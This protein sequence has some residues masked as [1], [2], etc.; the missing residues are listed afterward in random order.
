MCDH[1]PSRQFEVAGCSARIHPRRSAEAQL[2]C[3]AQYPVTGQP[4]KHEACQRL[5]AER[6]CP[7]ILINAGQNDQLTDITQEGRLTHLG[8]RRTRKL[9][10][11]G[12]DELADRRWVGVTQ[13]GRLGNHRAEFVVGDVE[14]GDPCPEQPGS[15]PWNF[16]FRKPHFVKQCLEEGGC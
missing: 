11:D 2:E 14:I 13:R 4:S 9:H 10:P 8:V 15:K 3:C 6:F 7:S 12:G 16:A 5:E 1:Y